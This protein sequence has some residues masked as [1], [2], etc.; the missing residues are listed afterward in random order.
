MG[1]LGAIKV[2]L[3]KLILSV[4]YWGCTLL[5]FDRHAVLLLSSRS[6][7]VSIGMSRIQEELAQDPTIHLKTLYYG[8][9]EAQMGLL[10]DAFKAVRL[11]AKSQVIVVDD[12]CFPLNA[13]YGKRKRNVTI[14]IWH[15]VGGFKKFGNAKKSKTRIP[16]KNYDYVC[17][18]SARDISTYAE[19]FSVPQNQVKVTGSIQIQY[20]EEVRAK[21]ANADVSPSKPVSSTDSSENTC[22][23]YVKLF[24]APTYRTGGNQDKSVKMM[25]ALI[26]RVETSQ[27]AIELKVSLHPYIDAKVIPAAYRVDRNHFYE[28]LLT[29]DV[30]I[31]DYSSLV[32]DYSVAQKP[33]LLWTPDLQEYT[34]KTGFFEGN[35]VT[36]GL[37]RVKDLRQLFSFIESPK[38]FTL[39]KKREASGLQHLSNQ[40][41]T[42]ADACGNICQLIRENTRV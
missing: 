39:L 37:V 36:E 21:L 15:A 7:S 18:N 14:Q 1:I 10:R 8:R 16:H 42:N 23:S 31:T 19:A 22:E 24:F 40:Y 26:K 20:I 13:L 6:T 35:D 41:F 2:E 29:S 17:V 4:T 5:P 38:N 34:N 27:T 3:L 28:E 12:H 33:I 9:N 32:I 11:I 30:L 25:Q